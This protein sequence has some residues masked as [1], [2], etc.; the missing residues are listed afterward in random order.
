L[1]P[2]KLK[3]DSTLRWE[4][5]R[6][7]R[8][9]TRDTGDW[10]ALS[11]AAQALFLMLLRKVDRIGE[12]HLGRRGVAAVPAMLGHPHQPGLDAALQELLADGCIRVT[13][14]GD[15][16]FVPNFLRAQEAA[17]SPAE[18]KREQRERDAA[19]AL[20][21]TQ[22][23]RNVTPV[24]SGHEMSPRAVPC[25]AEPSVPPVPFSAG[26]AVA[27]PPDPVAAF[28]GTPIQQVLDGAQPEK[29][30]G[31]IR[32]KLRRRKDDSPPNPRHHPLKLKLVAVYAEERGGAA[33]DFTGLDAKKLSEL[34]GKGS[35]EEIEARWRRG[36]RTEFKGRCDSLLDLVKNWNALAGSPSPPGR[37]VDLRKA[38]VRAEDVP[39]ES[40]AQTGLVDAKE[41][42]GGEW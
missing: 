30:S 24:T 1:T 28:G 38:P 9:Y 29:R 7:V 5:E 37:V 15:R 10:L 21:K 26:S 19:Q 22:L 34:L 17:K 42:F 20:E 16:L 23:S 6:Y 35:D 32:G 18:R 25:R 11:F 40:F 39:R 4:D 33:Y 14:A 41:A 31:K 8:V 12:L 27:P 36:L 3:G 13:D 2:E